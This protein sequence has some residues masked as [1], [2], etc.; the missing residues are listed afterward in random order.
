MG[1][2]EKGEKIPMLRLAADAMGCRDIRCEAPVRGA[3]VRVPLLDIEPLAS[4]G[5]ANRRVVEDYRAH[6]CGRW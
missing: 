2:W 5:T 3:R 6:V 1:G 4:A